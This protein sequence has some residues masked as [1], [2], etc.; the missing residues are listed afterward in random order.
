VFTEQSLHDNYFWK[1][2]LLGAYSEDCCPNYLLPEH[3]DTLKQ[4]TPRIRTH[5]QT[6]SQFLQEN[7]GAYTHFILLDHQDW[8][9]AHN[10][11]AL[12][13][14]WELILQN[15]APK[16]KILI[17]SAAA[18]VDFIPEFVYEKVYFD[19]EKAAA[20]EPHDRVGTY[21]SVLFGELK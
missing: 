15:S 3:F 9:A 21:A 5:T 17:R 12:Q 14:E 8:L 4:R 11:P 10:R 1:V 16:A 19:R 6:L 7:P 20:T 2:Y 18:T 13:E